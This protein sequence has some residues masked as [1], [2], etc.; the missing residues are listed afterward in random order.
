MND[1]PVRHQPPKLPDAFSD[2]LEAEISELGHRAVRQSIDDLAT[3][4]RDSKAMGQAKGPPADARTACAANMASRAPATFAILSD[5]LTTNAAEAGFSTARTMLD[6]GAGPGTATWSAMSCLPNLVSFTQLEP[7]PHFSRLAY[8]V[9][10][11]LR[12]TECVTFRHQHLK[13]LDEEERHDLV[14]ASY[15]LNEIPGSDVTAIIDKLW[16]VADGALIIVEPGSPLG[17]QRIVQVRAALIALG[18]HI[19]APC[20]NSKPCPVAENDWCHFSMRIPQTQRQVVTSLKPRDFNDEKYA[21]LIA[22]RQPGNPASARLIRR[23]IHGKGHVHLDLCEEGEVR[24]RTITRR[25]GPLYKDA[26][27]VRWGD[28]WPKIG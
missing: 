13:Q 19:I 24:R 1:L 18:A 15:V 16:R 8:A 11:R 7:N 2:V 26:R 25:D 10:S 28:P 21:Y 9:A 14:I 6:L 20:P 27:K 3:F 23:P 4:Y 12:K 22:S 5:L 17:F